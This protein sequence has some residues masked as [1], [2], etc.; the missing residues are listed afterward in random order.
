M[1]ETSEKVGVRLVVANTG[2]NAER[3]FDAGTT[4]RGALESMN[5]GSDTVQ[6][7]VN[8]K[9]VNLDAPLQT[10]DRIAVAPRN[11]KAA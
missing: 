10:G 11:M 9:A 4:V 6:V 2:L 8:R 1:S 7:R 3:Q 5:L